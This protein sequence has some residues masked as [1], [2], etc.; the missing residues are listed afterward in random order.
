[1]EKKRKKGYVTGIIGVIASAILS[2][3]AIDMGWNTTGQILGTFGVVFG[4]LGVG[5]IAKPEAVAPILD[6]IFQ[7]ILRSTAEKP[8][9]RVKQHQIKPRSSPQIFSGKGS[10]V[11]IKYESVR[12]KPKI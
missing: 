7:G 1:M 6:D 12:R 3:M 8:T 2:I 5:S 10:K 11:I 4:V 9:S